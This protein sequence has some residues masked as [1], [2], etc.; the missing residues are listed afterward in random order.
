MSNNRRAYDYD[1]VA[2][3]YL[4]AC[5]HGRPPTKAVGDVYGVPETTAAMLVRRVRAAGHLPATR[6]GRHH[7]SKDKVDAVAAS[8]GV[9][10]DEL[11]QAVLAHADGDLRIY[12]RR[13]E[14]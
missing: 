8:L 5:S 10:K 4:E 12:N 2:A 11:V 7:H 1:E 9:T 13:Q 3:V 14:G 6:Q